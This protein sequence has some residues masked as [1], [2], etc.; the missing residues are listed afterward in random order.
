MLEI[1]FTFYYAFDKL[2][3]IRF[4]R[5]K[6]WHNKEIPEYNDQQ[7]YILIYKIKERTKRK[8]KHVNKKL[9][10]IYMD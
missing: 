4:Y 1:E 5:T 2:T 6:V 7:F 9:I 8:Q 10:S 3:D